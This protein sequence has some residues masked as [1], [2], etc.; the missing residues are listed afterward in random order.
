MS[1]YFHIYGK[2]EYD[3]ESIVDAE[4]ANAVIRYAG[5]SVGGYACI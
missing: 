4:K 5:R 1:T 3:D 2:D